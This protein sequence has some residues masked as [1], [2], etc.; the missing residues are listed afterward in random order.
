[1]YITHVRHESGSFD[2]SYLSGAFAGML[3][4]C[5]MV[6]EIIV[7]DC[8]VRCLALLQLRLLIHL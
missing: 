1:M 5:R 6:S 7:L 4:V 8:G 3:V 2:L